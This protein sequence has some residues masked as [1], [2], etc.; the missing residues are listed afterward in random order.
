M[1]F[2]PKLSF[3]SEENIQYTS[4]TVKY[5]LCSG[6]HDLD[7]IVNS[8]FLFLYCITLGQISLTKKGTEAVNIISC[9]QPSIMNLGETS[10]YYLIMVMVMKILRNRYPLPK[11]VKKRVL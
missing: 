6:A 11:L 2:S 4:I 7:L 8:H 3:S 9:F 1:K 10:K 5:W